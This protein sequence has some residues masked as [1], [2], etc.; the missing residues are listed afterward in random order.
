RPG[1]TPDQYRQALN[2]A[3]AVCQL[4]PDNGF[5]LNTLG[6][7]QYRV[8]QYEA[9]LATLTRSDRL[10][11]AQFKKSLPADLAFL[12]MTQHQLGR[13]EQAQA[14]L[15][16]LRGAVKQSPRTTS[17][18]DQALLTEAEALLTGPKP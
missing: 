15:T 8:G 2:R 10:N 1:A 13:N 6:A 16:L 11:A 3:E 14:T 17:A 12:A 9:A 18:E 4:E 7:A 5:Y